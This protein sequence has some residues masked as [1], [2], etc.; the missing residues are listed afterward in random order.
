MTADPRDRERQGGKG[1]RGINEVLRGHRG[2]GAC[3]RDVNGDTW[4]CLIPSNNHSRAAKVR[5]LMRA[6]VAGLRARTFRFSLCFKSGA[7]T[8]P[9]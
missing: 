5:W 4:L 6:W 2:G 7:R 3:K 9:S 8:Q 1:H